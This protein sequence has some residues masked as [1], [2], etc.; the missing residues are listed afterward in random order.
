[1]ERR[2]F[3]VLHTTGQEWVKARSAAEALRKCYVH[4]GYRHARAVIDAKVFPGQKQLS[5]LRAAPF[6]AFIDQ[7]VAARKQ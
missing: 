2:D 4:G 7:P 3:V 1:M 6:G 5:P